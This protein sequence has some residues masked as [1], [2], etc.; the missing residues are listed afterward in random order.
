MDDPPDIQVCRG[1]INFYPET[2][3]G[4]LHRRF[5]ALILPMSRFAGEVRY[6]ER[7]WSPWWVAGPYQGRRWSGQNRKRRLSLTRD[8]AFPS[9]EGQTCPLTVITASAETLY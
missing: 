3:K 5:N 2:P 1:K 8:A 6:G 9:D 7:L 4:A